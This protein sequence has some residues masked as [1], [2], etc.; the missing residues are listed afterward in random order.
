MAALSHELEIAKQLIEK[1]FALELLSPAGLLDF[2]ILLLLIILHYS[3]ELLL[4]ALRILSVLIVRLF[5]RSAR[6]LYPPA[7]ISLS[8][9]IGVFVG[10]FILSVVVLSCVE[11]IFKPPFRTSDLPLQVRILK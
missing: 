4:G 6:G 5:N 2:G 7:H 3:H 1:A 11:W 9:S 10:Y 8:K